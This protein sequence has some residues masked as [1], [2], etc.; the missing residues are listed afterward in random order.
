MD[1]RGLTDP[2]P[3]VRPRTFELWRAARGG[4]LASVRQNV[5]ASFNRFP[6]GWSAGGM[7]RY[8]PAPEV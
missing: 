4:R 3:A 1:G 8:P 6:Y 7:V 5:L 2:S